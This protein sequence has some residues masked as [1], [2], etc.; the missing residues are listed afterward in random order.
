MNTL[1]IEATNR[2]TRLGEYALASGP[3]AVRRLFILH[4]IYGPAGRRL[5]LEAGLKPG[6]HIADFGCGVGAVTHM[7]AEMTGPTGSVTGIDVSAAQIGQAA[8]ICKNAGL[9]NV[10][11]GTADACNSGLPREA[12]DL[13]YCRFLLLHLPDPAACLREMRDVLKPDGLLVIEDGDLASAASIPPTALNAFAYLFTRLGPTRGLD[14]SLSNNLYHMVKGAGFSEPHIEIHQPAACRS[15]NG[16]LLTWSVAEA[17]AAFVEAGL[18]T[19]P[20]LKRTLDE[21]EA[22]A[23]DPDVLVLAPRMSVV[24]ARKAA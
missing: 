9:K 10:M 15:D 11:F 22:A 8:Q 20:Q 2:Q 21:M 5:L 13:V 18:I 7:L 12:Y 19:R 14:Y 3:A 16:T 17:G 1:T 4:N 6:M 23:N 24:W